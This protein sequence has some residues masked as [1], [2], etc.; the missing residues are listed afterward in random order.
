MRENK[1]V[2][3]CVHYSYKPLLEPIVSLRLEMLVDKS[4]LV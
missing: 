3:S 2:G 1:Y 4:P